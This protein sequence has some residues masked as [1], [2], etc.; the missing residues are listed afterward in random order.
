MFWWPTFAVAHRAFRQADIKPAGGDVDRWILGH[1]PIGDRV[2]G[3]ID[4]IGVV[5]L[6][7]RIQPQP[8]RMIRTSGV[9]TFDIPAL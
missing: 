7:L 9:L 5:P 8:S 1:Q 2:L 3:E 6:R 4:G